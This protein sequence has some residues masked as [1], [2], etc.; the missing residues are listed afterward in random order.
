MITE[1]A[2]YTV[3]PYLK[4]SSTSAG[5]HRLRRLLAQHKISINQN[6]VGI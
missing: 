5:V 1:F 3:Y 6:K 4:V 2:K